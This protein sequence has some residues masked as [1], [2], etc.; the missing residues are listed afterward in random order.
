MDSRKWSEI[1]RI[2][3]DVVDLSAD[4]RASF[5]A[6]N[7]ADQE[8][9][10]EVGKLI[11]SD[12]KAETLDGVDF[13]RNEI[14]R[15]QE[16]GNYKILEEI[17]SGGMG[18]VFLAIREDLQKRVALKIIKYDFSSK[19]L[20]RRFENER[21]IL[22]ALEHQ[23]IA[24]L[25]DGGSTA[26]G[27]PYFVMEYV[28]GEELLT[29]CHNRQLAIDERLEIFRKICTAVSYAHSKLIVHR[30]LKPS[31]ILIS[32]D[33]EPKLLDFG[34]SK[35]LDENSFEQDRTAT[36][37]G[38]MTPNY[39]SPEQFRGEP[40]S[41]A[42]DVYSLGVILFELLTGN[43]PY[44]LKNKPIDEVARI[45]GNVEAARPSSVFNHSRRVT[46]NEKKPLLS[47]EMQLV[48]K[49]R[50]DLDNIILKSL[51]KEASER[52]AS[53]EKFSED[54]RRYLEGLPVTARPATY[55]Y[56]ASKFIQRNKLPVASASFGTVALIGG[57]AATLWQSFQANKQKNLAEK[58]FSEVRQLANNVLFKYHDAIENLPGSTAARELLI[59][60]A[61]RYLDNLA[62]E[63][64]GDFELE[65]EL[66]NAYLKIG[67]V[68][69]RVFHPN[70]GNSD[71]ALLNYRKSLK[72][73]E[74][75]RLQQPQNVSILRAMF[76]L[77]ENC[78]LLSVRRADWQNLQKIAKKCFEVADR[79][80]EIEP[81]NSDFQA[82]KVRSYLSL[83]E[84]VEFTEGY[85]GQ[86]EIYREGYLLA[87]SLLDKNPDDI[88]IIRIFITL[89]QRIATQTEY[90]CDTLREAGSP[91]KE[92]LSKLRD[93]YRIHLDT[94]ERC[95]L[96]SKELPHNTTISRSVGCTLNNVG[97]ALAR[98]GEGGESLQ[99]T[100]RA[101]E[102]FTNIAAL[103][104]QNKE[105]QRDVADGFQYVGMSY[106]AL[107][108]YQS[109][110]KNYLNALEKLKPLTGTDA[111]NF[112]FLEQTH[113]V[114]NKI[115]DCF[116]KL[117][118]FANA[119]EY[120]QD[121]YDLIEK[122]SEKLNPQQIQLLSVISL[123]KL[124][125]CFNWLL[126]NL[127]SE[128]PEIRQKF[129]RQS[130]DF[131]NRAYKMLIALEN[132]RQLSWVYV[133]KIPLLK[134]KIKQISFS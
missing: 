48:K 38:M 104:P 4:A 103:D 14:S 50:G 45:I 96:M 36:A 110:V 54:I 90:W 114:I 101:L 58:R 17:G 67:D 118:D 107:G 40:A 82:L 47:E 5:F 91:E 35:L 42:T 57:I 131:Y 81:H 80:I 102:R 73:F 24:R 120:Y 6:E 94:L 56:L 126:Q 20:K 92:I 65:E 122:A 22:A 19:Q 116:L 28:E 115:G 13:S 27:L 88:P 108:D 68:Q 89:E 15:P 64:Y 18:A 9:I 99:H 8:I 129:S 124:G 63:T 113:A 34:I 23:N 51:R 55:G 16:I 100:R 11:N 66:A 98:L 86:I 49:L 112:E 95:L 12:L 105:A 70:L 133:Y 85:A 7:C 41:T 71:N 3:N 84:M 93:A 106:A 97:S 78:I 76:V 83:G 46:A 69:G 52:Y 37:L 74:K 32:S 134:G 127:S 59:N 128:N 1:K 117:E 123:E 87:K 61:T 75:L 39:A 26:N 29:Y 72:L 53:V 21:R 30:D 109:A 60:D 79:L 62:S 121:G 10:A 25:L 43:L 132:Q 31:N 44:R 125:D 77:C 119:A 111:A 2:F 33:G 130:L